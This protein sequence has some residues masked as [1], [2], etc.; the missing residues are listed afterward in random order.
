MIGASAD[1]ISEWSTSLGITSHTFLLFFPIDRSKNCLVVCLAMVFLCL[2]LILITDCLCHKWLDIHYKSSSPFKTIFKVLN[3]ARKT[4]YPEHRS[5]FTYIDKKEPSRLDYGK[6][7][8][9][10]PFTEEEDVKTIFGMLPL[11]IS[12]F[13]AD[14]TFQSAHSRQIYAVSDPTSHICSN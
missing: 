9:G 10:R 3:Y 7:K 4:K 12:T 8:F 11:Y 6:H 5:A 1:D 13:V 14:G 2:S